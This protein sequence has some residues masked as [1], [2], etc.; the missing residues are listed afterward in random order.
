MWRKGRFEEEKE[1]EEVE[2]EE[3]RVGCGRRGVV[4]WRGMEC[5]PSVPACRMGRLV[6]TWRLRSPLRKGASSVKESCDVKARKSR[7]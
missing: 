3:K 5:F 7:W 4:K 2:E 6:G 1:E